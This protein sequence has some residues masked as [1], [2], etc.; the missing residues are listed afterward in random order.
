[1]SWKNVDNYFFANGTKIRLNKQPRGVER[2]IVYSSVEPLQIDYA[3]GNVHDLKL[4]ELLEVCTEWGRERI[5][6]A[7]VGGRLARI[8]F[9]EIFED[10]EGEEV[11]RKHLGLRR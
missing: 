7:N 1:M 2:Y 10:V 3:P 8:F 11:L 4:G 6:Y 5:F 9:T